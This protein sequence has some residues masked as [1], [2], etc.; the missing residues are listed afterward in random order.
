M[1]TSRRDFLK[2]LGL[3]AAT[4]PVASHVVSIK[5]REFKQ[6][7]DSSGGQYFMLEGTEDGKK[8]EVAIQGTEYKKYRL[9]VFPG[10]T[11][12]GR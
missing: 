3:A 6:E 7:F 1:S 11:I 5:K 12:R 2:F 4:V 10:G 8:W 9:D